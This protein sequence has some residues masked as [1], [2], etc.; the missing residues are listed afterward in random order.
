MSFNMYAE[1]MQLQRLSKLGNPLEKLEVIDFESFRPL[2]D[3][4]FCRERKNNADRPL[5]DDVMMFKI[6]VLQRLFNLSDVQIEYQITDRISFQ[7]FIGLSLGERVPAAKT[8][9][10]FRDTLTQSGTIQNLFMAFNDMLATKGIVTHTETSV[11][12]TFVK[13]P[14]RRSSRDENKQVKNDETPEE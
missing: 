14:R 5:F 2:L 12:V 9:G 7:H 4:A 10:Q 1:E 8:I 13:V 6:L 11:N 3:N